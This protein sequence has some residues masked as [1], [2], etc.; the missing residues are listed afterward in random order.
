M[1]SILTKQ[2]LCSFFLLLSINFIS[3]QTTREF[4]KE[5]LAVKAIVDQLF[6]GMR[7]GDST[8]VR[9]TFHQKATLVTTFTNKKKEKVLE[10][11]KVDQFIE[12]VVH[13]MIKFGMS[14]FL[15]TA[16]R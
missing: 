6:D 8:M 12:A 9:A 5:Q 3:A 2:V 16:F 1:K 4:T 11:G 15:V 10:H 13:H 7:A 14:I